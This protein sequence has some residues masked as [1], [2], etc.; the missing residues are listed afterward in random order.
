MGAFDSS[1]YTN[2]P[3]VACQRQ[4][5]IDEGVQINSDGIATPTGKSFLGNGDEYRLGGFIQL[6]T[7]LPHN[8]G[9]VLGG[10]VDYHPDFGAQFNPRVS[11]V[12]PIAWGLYAKAQ[13]SQADV[14]P[15]FL[16]RNGNARSDFIGNPGIRPQAITTYEALIGFSKL[17]MR[18]EVNGYINQVRDFIAYDVQ[19][20]ARTG[21]YRF[22]NQG[23]LDLG[24]AEA[25]LQLTAWQKRLA[26]DMSASFTKA[27]SSSD[28]Q[29]LVN[30]EL[31]GP[32]KFP[33]FIGALIVNFTPVPY[34]NFN[35]SG[36]YTG[37]ISTNI[38]AE[39]R[40]SDI[41]GT[42]GMNYTSKVAS[43]YAIQSFTLNANAYW[44]FLKH[45][46]VT[47]TVE[48]MTNARYYRP[49]SVLV[50]YLMPGTVFSGALAFRY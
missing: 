22:T 14:Y 15:A 37:P 13:F 43:A 4:A 3:D 42:D 6:G 46:R 24:G 9:V 10:R 35:V 40:F 21:K 8:I 34:L 45:W 31:G 47:A 19:E 2:G 48:N 20:N 49:G 11:L 32:S 28:P 41:Q 50:P 26:F 27:L 16:Y 7:F 5:M 1:T 39:V 12:A 44:T 36:I 33:E 25:T 30:G 29:F 18:L 23:N 38:P 17:F